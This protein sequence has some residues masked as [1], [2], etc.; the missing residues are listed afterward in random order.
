MTSAVILSAGQGK[1]LLPHT[2]HC[3]KCLL[4][5]KGKTILEWQIDTLL[6]TGIHEVN[7]VTGFH[8]DLVDE[9]LEKRYQGNGQIK[10][11]LNPFFDVSDNLA[12]CWL[13]RHAMQG[14]F[15][16]I[17]GDTLFERAILDTVLNSPV[18]PVTLTI[19]FKGSYD[20]D[21]M[22]VELSENRVVHV[23]KALIPTQTHAE[24]IGL[25][26]FRENG[27][28]LFCAALEKAMRQSRGLKSWFLS[29]I[30]AMA[31]QQLVTSCSISGLRWAEIDFIDDLDSARSIFTE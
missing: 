29:V 24:S 11:L 14:D 9:L 8:A 3:P 28:E 22:K 18:S 21:D 16:L 25:L 30:D 20:E 6:A 31:G 17:N 10:T 15:V 12:S 27:P 26:Y 19:D 5:V 1:R 13:A 7:I 4:T 23:S 2:E